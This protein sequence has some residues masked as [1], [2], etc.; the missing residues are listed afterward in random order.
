MNNSD[1]DKTL[2]AARVPEH[3]HDYWED[4]PHRVLAQLRNTPEERHAPSS[5]RPRL[6]WGFGLVFACLAVGFAIGHWHGRRQTSDPWALLRNEKLL[7]EVLT[8]FPNRVRAIM[9]DE[10]GV[11]LVLSDNPDVPLSTPLWIK[12]CEGNRCQAAVTFSGQELQIAGRR[13]EVL[14]DAQGN[15][16]LVGNHLYWSSTRPDRAPGDLR[17][18]ARPLEYTM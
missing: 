5:R 7:H 3:P 4:F 12:I 16:M 11:Q 13:V 8:F 17:I 1:L 9:Q 10:H 18:Q 15:I 6:A 2:K 14:A